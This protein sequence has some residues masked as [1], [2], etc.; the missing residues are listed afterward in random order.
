MS[1]RMLLRRII[2]R[3]EPPP[4]PPP[5]PAPAAIEALHIAENKLI[6]PDDV[7]K[8]D[9]MMS[10]KSRLIGSFKLCISTSGHVSNVTLLKSTESP[11]YDEEL[12]KEL[13][14]WRY[15]PFIVDG[16]PAPVCT[17]VRFIC[18]QQDPD[19]PASHPDPR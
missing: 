2:Y 5:L 11:S 4:P 8:A 15:R 17:A 12:R 3:R 19:P 7:T 6:V 13:L 9:I 10:G 16:R 1:E 18:S 14:Q